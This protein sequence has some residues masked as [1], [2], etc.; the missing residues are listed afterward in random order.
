MLAELLENGLVE[1]VLDIFRLY[2]VLGTFSRS[3][4]T[5]RAAATYTHVIESGGR[6]GALVRLLLVSGLSGV[7]S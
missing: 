5:R 2:R 7:D 6:G 4:N 3:I 1:E